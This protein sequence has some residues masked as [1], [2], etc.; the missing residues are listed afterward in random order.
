MLSLDD[1]RPLE[2]EDRSLFL[3]FLGRYPPTHSDL[4]FGNLYAWRSYANYQ[5]TLVRDHL[6]L[7]SHIGGSYQFGY[8]VG[9]HDAK[10]VRELLQLAREI[11]ASPL[12]ELID[13]RA[14]DHLSDHLPQLDLV[15][16]RDCYDYIYLA[17]ELAS[18]PGKHF[19]NHR[20]IINKFRRSYS[21]GIEDVSRENFGEVMEFLER[22]CIWKDCDG[23]PSLEAE[24]TALLTAVEHFG[25]LE[26]EGIVLRVE[27]DI[28]ALSI[29]EQLNED[30]VAV[31]Y[32]KADVNYE[33]IYQV[34]NQ[35]TARRL[36]SRFT[37][38]NREHDLGIPGLR[39]AKE[40]YRPHHMVEV[41]LVEG[42]SE[43]L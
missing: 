23:N 37:F 13:S 38:M 33:G 10:I 1:F 7:L 24:K 40:R 3:D 16:C 14:R 19:L 4:S 15:P 21:H 8:P 29:Y 27:G 31:H 26:L 32:E 43:D 35:E 20:N 18:L 5:W 42:L 39:K 17:R 2:L 28:Q 12:L 6:I 25:A 9:D 11:K 34:I 41:Y 36:E 30:T 22:W